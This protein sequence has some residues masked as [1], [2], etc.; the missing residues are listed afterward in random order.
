LIPDRAKH[1]FGKKPREKAALSAQ[2]CAYNDGRQTN[3]SSQF[4]SKAD[5]V[6]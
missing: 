2:T 6:V 5:N 1:P 4:S 3:T